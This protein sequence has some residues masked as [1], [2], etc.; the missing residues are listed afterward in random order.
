MKGSIAFKVGGG[1]NGDNSYRRMKDECEW[2]E[3]LKF[4]HRMRIELIQYERPAIVLPGHNGA[5]YWNI[6]E[7]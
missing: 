2:L 5:R 7:R 6:D 3:L 4:G 1:K